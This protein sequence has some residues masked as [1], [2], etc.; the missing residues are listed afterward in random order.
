[1]SCNF[2]DVLEHTKA[3]HALMHMAGW[4]EKNQT[5]TAVNFSLEE[6]GVDCF[7]VDPM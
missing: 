4:A 6:S 2:F 1:M 3:I 5:F 7:I